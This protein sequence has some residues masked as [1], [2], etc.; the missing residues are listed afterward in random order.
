MD[1]SG[2]QDTPLNGP[3]SNDKLSVLQWNCR[4]IANKIHHLMNYLRN[5]K[6][7][8]IMPQSL[9]V[10][11]HSLHHLE[12]WEWESYGCHISQHTAEMPPPESPARAKNCRLLSCSVTFQGRVTRQRNITLINIYYLSRLNSEL[13]IM[14]NLALTTRFSSK[15]MGH[16][17]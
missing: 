9:N 15:Q 8:V 12:A 17:R 3:E 5:P 7:D 16:R 1:N 2:S 14:S 13:T 4:T 10:K 6:Q 11:P